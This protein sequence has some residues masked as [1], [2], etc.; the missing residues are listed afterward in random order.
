MAVADLSVV[1]LHHESPTARAW[2]RLLRRKSAMFGLVVITLFVL[3]AVFAPLI[4]PYDPAQQSWTSIRKPPSM[5]HWLGTVE[6]SP[7]ERAEISRQ[8]IAIIPAP[9]GIGN[10]RAT[11]AP[12]LRLLQALAAAVLLVACANLASLLL[13][14]GA[15]RRTEM[16][17]RVALGECGWS[18]NC[19]SNQHCWRRSA[20]PPAW[21]CRSPAPV[22]SS[23]WRSAAR[24]AS[25][26][27]RPPQ[28]W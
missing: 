10:M 19:S 18:G 15:A 28:G 11:V 2:R 9:S 8:R 7:A 4:A 27:I 16:A 17:M 6:L 23:S 21:S 22:R 1:E 25:R 5:Q 26:S 13:A 14:R 12:S 24:P 3:I 20:G